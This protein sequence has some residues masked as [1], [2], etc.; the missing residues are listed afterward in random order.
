[1][2]SSRDVVPLRS[3]T[4]RPLRIGIIAPPVLPLPPVGYAGTERIIATLALGLHDRGHQ[5]T[6]FAAGDSD[7]PCEV[8]PVVPKA[9]WPAGYRGN[10]TN[11]FDLAVA[12]AWEQQDR[13]DVFHSH[14]DV[15]GFAMARHATTPVITTLHG[16]LDVGGTM[17]L[18]DAYPDIPLVAIS[19]SQRRWNPD[20]DWVATI[21]HGLDFSTA[22]RSATPG[23]HLLLV[24]RLTR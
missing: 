16:R 5:V 18:I 19:A 13:F 23:E 9:L 11:Y 24:G 2:S 15:A 17:E 10:L 21:P 14:V 20:A 4:H 7:L 22:P 1:M 8:V 12:R 6:V 3:R